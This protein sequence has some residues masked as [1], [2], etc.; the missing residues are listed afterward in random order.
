MMIAFRCQCDETRIRCSFDIFN[1]EGEIGFENHDIGDCRCTND[2]KMYERKDGSL[3]VLCSLCVLTT[4]KE[5]KMRVDV[6]KIYEEIRKRWM[7]GD[8]KACQGVREYVAIKHGNLSMD[9]NAD[10]NEIMVLTFAGL[11][12]MLMN[13]NYD[14]KPG[15]ISDIKTVEGGIIKSTSSNDN[16]GTVVL[17]PADVNRSKIIF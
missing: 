13:E 11:L 1:V 16:A 9:P 5:V 12:I 2:L 14:V 15:T 17:N 4:D 7:E 3:K 8:E 10:E 6:Q